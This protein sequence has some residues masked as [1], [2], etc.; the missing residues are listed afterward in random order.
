MLGLT[1]TDSSL[2]FTALAHASP[3]WE[4][5]ETIPRLPTESESSNKKILKG[6][7]KLCAGRRYRWQT[8]SWEARAIE[9]SLDGS[10]ITGI[11]FSYG[12]CFAFPISWGL[13]NPRRLPFQRLAD[14]AVSHRRCNYVIWHWDQYYTLL[15]QVLLL[16]IITNR[17][18]YSIV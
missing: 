17:H 18:L 8:V 4:T 1:L 13:K 14:S 2:E 12:S 11:F 6:N 5:L 9:A 3:D 15:L 7:K 16:I 10:R